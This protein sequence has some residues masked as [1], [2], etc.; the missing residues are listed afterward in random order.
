MRKFIQILLLVVFMA[1]SCPSAM[2][3]WE[4]GKA[5]EGQTVA[6]VKTLALAA[7]L[8]TE[9]K[10]T[11]TLEEFVDV[12]NTR[13][14]K[15]S[16]KKYKVVPYDVIAKDV[17]QR[18]GKN[19]YTL[20]RIPSTRVFKNNVAQYADAYLVATVTMSRRTV[21]FFEVYS[22][23]THELLYTY[24][25]ILA[26]DELDNVRTYSDMV[27]LFYDEFAVAIETQK[28]EQEDAEKAA[29]KERE[30]AE[31]KAQREREKAAQNAG[32]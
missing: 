22:A 18:T 23:V 28:K 11:P 32:K 26:P 30:K 2:A 27:S 17:L 13:G 16:P 3:Y 21:L 14:A 1:V 8:Y 24:Q 25:I 31:R 10:G 19:L 12:L 4:E 20:A 9:K 6:H 5:Q 15:V 7:P 29:R